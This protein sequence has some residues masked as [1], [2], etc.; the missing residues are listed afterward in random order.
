M[1]TATTC[2]P[3]LNSP[4]TPRLSLHRFLDGEDITQIEFEAEV[5]GFTELLR[6]VRNGFRLYSTDSMDTLPA[7]SNA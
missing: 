6:S 2:E 4:S 5:S 7:R 3:G 1:E